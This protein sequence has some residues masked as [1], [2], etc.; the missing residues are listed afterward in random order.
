MTQLAMLR[1]HRLRGGLL[2]FWLLLPLACLSAVAFLTVLPHAQA[3]AKEALS[4]SVA[5]SLAPQVTIYR[6]EYGVP[7][8]VG[9]TDESTIFGF[10][11]AQAEDFLWQVED[12]YLLALGRYCEAHGPQ[13]L[14]SDLL[15]RAFEI[16]PRSQRDFAA[17]DEQTRQLLTAFT[18]GIN[19]YVQT[20]P[21]A[22]LRL[23]KQFEPWHALAHH[24]QMALELAFRFTGLGNDY[25]PRRN[26]H[27]WTATGSNGWAIS[28][29][30]TD[31]GKPMLLAAPHMPWHGF[32]QLAEAHLT[33]LGGPE[34]KRWNFIGAHFY[35]SPVLALGHNERLGWT[36]VSNNP[37]IA[38]LWRVKFPSESKP[39]EYLYDQGVRNA[40]EWKETIRVRKSRGWEDREFTFRKTHY[41]PIVAKDGNSSLAARISGLYESVPMRQSLQMMRAQN[42]DEFRTALAP[43]QILYMNVIYADVDGNIMALYNGRIPRRNP[44]FDWSKPVDGSNPATAWLGIH[45]LEELPTVLNP[46]AG[47]VQN[48]NSSPL[49]TT[50]GDNPAAEDFPSYMIRDVGVRNRRALR[51]LEI[52]RG[53][54]STTFDQWQAAAFDTQ[55][56]WAKHE[57]PKYADHLEALKQTQPEQ[58]QK[59][60]PYLAHLLAWDAR[61]THDS[62]AATLC[63][64]WYEELYGQKYPGETLRKKFQD[65]PDLQLL[66]LVRTAERLQAMHGTWQIPYGELYRTQRESHVADLTDA[67]FDDTAD[68]L[69]CIGG[70]GPMGVALTQYYTPSVDIPLVISQRRRY[71][72]VGSSYLA[73]YDFSQEPVRGAS[74]VN[75]GTSGKANSPHYFDQ[76]KLLSDQKMKPERFTLKDVRS[77]AVRSYHPGE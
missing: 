18:A 60:R 66:A 64:A 6:D 31:S 38:D 45:S 75:Y 48:C 55:V 4:Q 47:F 69:P 44:D 17:L 72:L 2:G 68:S 27:I 76:A 5:E 57:L 53:M 37:D 70:H 43:M 71:S 65:H 22:K 32:A 41:G 11:Y 14:N 8:I 42:L 59:V 74:V 67:R 34:G 9:K 12:S 26:P 39:L 15:N 62:T 13:G 29:Q 50:D 30:R 28:G 19:H 54:Q 56:Y 10:G 24:R 35:G 1:P 52:L 25:L 3:Q 73:A 36:L 21:D 23:L 33:S 58:A 49:I 40:T 61:I 7:H 16:A 77:S 51:S 20:H 46:A 63:H